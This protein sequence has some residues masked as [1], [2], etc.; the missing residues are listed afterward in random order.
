MMTR[1]TTLK[2]KGLRQGDPLSPLLFNIVAHMLAIFIAR[3]KDDGH[4]A[5]L[6]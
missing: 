6:T 1:I 3:A 4:V 2:T 5:G